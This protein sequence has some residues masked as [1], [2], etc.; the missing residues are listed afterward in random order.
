MTSPSAAGH[1]RS[2]TIPATFFALACGVV[3]LHLC[4]LWLPTINLEWAFI[5]AARYFESGDPALL[6]RYHEVQANTL[7]VPYLA[8][9]LGMFP[10]LDITTAPRILSAI[11][12]LL[13]AGALYRF[14]SLLGSGP[15]T[16]LLALV[17][18]NPLIWTFS[19]RGTADFLPA[20]LA[21]FSLTG[22]LARKP[23]TVATTFCCLL[24]GIAITLKY[25]AAFLLPIIWLEALSRGVSS[26]ML[27]TTLRRTALV[28]AIP[29]G[30]L[31][32][33]RHNLGF[34][35]TPPAF[36][37]A[38]GVRLS[39]GTWLTNFVAYLGYLG[40]LLF[41][42]LLTGVAARASGAG[43]VRWSAAGVLLFVTG[44]W[45]LTPAGEMNL[46]PLDAFVRPDLLHGAL[47]VFAGLFCAA[48]SRQLRDR[49]LDHERRRVLLV[50]LLG[51]LAFVAI[52]SISRP[53]QRYL[54]F[55]LP[56]AFLLL[57][58][59]GTRPWAHVFAATLVAYGLLN[60]FVATKQYATGIAALQMVEEITERGLLDVTDPGIILGHAGDRFPSLAP[61][62]ARYTVVPGRRDDA[63]VYTENSPLPLI[64]QGFSLVQDTSRVSP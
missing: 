21:L 3:L 27:I 41:P 18:L 40:L 16:L 42:V 60:S 17:L 52:L 19:G 38:L 57:P 53:S 62:M 7:G 35:V 61:E 29:L 49:G 55:I 28:C 23:G 64:R 34:W 45:L 4:L 51:C 54:L 59:P 43:A 32:L 63:L 5:T 2:P 8:H 48:A 25:H 30:Y 1:T 31:I 46:G 9:L 20:A 12:T 22:L 44:Y 56:L 15:S 36:Q 47:C 58:T 33:V 39:I 37:D 14:S 6:A 13:L 50:I 26:G 10:G 11:A 24:F